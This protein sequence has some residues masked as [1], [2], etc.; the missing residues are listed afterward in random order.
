MNVP[1]RSLRRA[2]A[3]PHDCPS[4]C[5]LEVEVLDS[6]TI[7]RLYGAADNS[8]TAG[9]ICAK[10]A[11]YAERVHNP[12]RLTEALLRTGPKG[13]GQFTPIGMDEALDR[14]ADGLLAAEARHGAEAVWP[15]FYAGTMGLVMRDGINRL[16]HA[17]RYSDQYSTICTALSWAGYLAGNGRM[18]GADP[19]EMER[20]DCIVLWGTNAVVT[21]VNVMTHAVRARKSRGAPIV[22]VDIYDNATLRQADVP[23]IVRPGT[24]GAL[25]C[26]IMHVL[27]R[28]GFAD[29]AY[30][31]RFADD[32]AGL[33]AHLATRTPEWA[34]AICGVPADDITA[35]AHLLGRRPR[36]FFR[37]GYGF[38]RSRNG[39]VAMHAVTSLPVVLGSWR[40]DGGGALHSNSGMFGWN[41]RM[42]EGLDLRDGGV[43]QLDQSRIGAVL[44]GEPSALRGGPPVTALFI[45]N[46]NPVSVAPDQ[47]VVKR[48]FARHDLFT[49]VHEQIMTDTAR[50]ADI[51][52][53]ATMFVEHDDVYQGG[54]Q[55]HIL[56]GPKLIDPPGACRSNHDVIC[57]LAKRLGAAHPAFDMTAR[58]IID[59]TLRESGRGTLA[60]LEQS[61]WIDCAQPFE[62]AHFLEGF[63]WPD[64]KFRFRP[65]WAGAA[66]SMPGGADTAGMPVFPDHWAV[67]EER[68]AA[69]PFRMATSPARNFLNSTFTEAPTSLA[70][71]ERPTVMIHPDDAVPLGIA[72]GSPVELTSPRGAVQLH[73]RLF[74]GLRRGV[75]IAESIWPNTAYPDGRGINT[76][77]GADAPPPLGGAAFHD[78]KVAIRLRDQDRRPAAVP[79]P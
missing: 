34:S 58:E 9:V 50:M 78:N 42:I 53:P 74:E 23:L 18:T 59:L 63:G 41:K 67:T 28:D 15:Y 19:R 76:L 72:D 47:E 65:D 62:R 31:A 44:T 16:R 61:R 71:E 54:G 46:T 30:L 57:G 26:G 32:P 69:F 6:R 55:S 14:V 11:R 4:T 25:A 49:V 52:L 56:L 3:C 21:Q 2:S 22:A 10:V 7:G 38:A 48:G 39:A 64:G 60:D 13:S 68:D 12:N 8:Y 73:A 51:V 75:L 17:K 20:S 5:A 77:T 27:F 33:E 70:K 36:A 45:Q 24:D 35:L 29:R 79:G 37:I 40:Y 43:R 1:V 66:S